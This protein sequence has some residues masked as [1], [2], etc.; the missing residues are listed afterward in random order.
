MDKHKKSTLISLFRRK[1][2][3]IGVK[4]DTGFRVK[5]GMTKDAGIHGNIA[6]FELL[7]G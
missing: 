2:E 5:H 4:N 1:S 3:S 7:L 6:I